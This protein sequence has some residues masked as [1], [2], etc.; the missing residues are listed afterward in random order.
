M[1]NRFYLI[2]VLIVLVTI[3]NIQNSLAAKKEFFNESKN[4]ISFKQKALNIVKLKEKLKNSTSDLEMMCSKQEN[5]YICK[6]LDK[7]KFQKF[8]YAL[9]KVNIKTLKIEKKNGVNAYLEIE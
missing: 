1:K 8:E 4:S 6:N 9:K 7:N 2:A 3:I 5:R